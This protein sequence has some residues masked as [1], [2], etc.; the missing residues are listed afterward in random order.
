MRDTLT[1]TRL[2]QK[3]LD[4]GLKQADLAGQVGISASYL[5]LIEH[6][7]RGIS[8]A[9]LTSIA[10]ALA[11]D[12]EHLQEGGGARLVAAL[13]TLGGPE[14]AGDFAA[15]FPD[16]AEFLMRQSDRISALE[17]TVSGLDDRLSHDPVLT[18][19]MHDVL[20]T[21]SA[22]RSTSSILVETP[23]LEADWRARFHANIDA[24]SRRLAET[25]A[26]MVAHFDKIG[27]SD[28]NF[29]TPLEAVY[30][31]FDTHGFFIPALEQDPTDAQVA[32]F[33]A[34]HLADADAGARDL[35]TTALRRYIRVARTMP[36]EPFISTAI[37][38]AHDP[39]ALAKAFDTGLED[40]FL[41]YAHLPMRPDLPEIGF[42]S[43][44][45][46]G[47]LTMRRPAPGF[48]MPRFG[49]ACPLWPLFAAFTQSPR[50]LRKRLVTM[51]GAVYTAY[52]MAGSRAAQEFDAPPI[53]TAAMLL[54]RAPESEDSASNGADFVG[55][56]C[57][58]CTKAQ[59]AA[60][61]EGSIL[62]G[63]NL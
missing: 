17:E 11:I 10:Q 61:R 59:C 56:S 36:A 8:G 24:E 19:K 51:E 37:A 12:P 39:S 27:Q 18:E 28:R 5:N 13:E 50:P 9:L 4:L 55:S 53:L 44:D 25:S 52:A 42:V 58:V 38:Q 20:S 35:V 7:R 33:V 63:A 6:N 40:V 48:A 54:I 2:R 21:V 49:A 57:R 22:I 62:P 1:G 16:W 45:M 60:R 43:C 47:G 14:R 3:R 26:A 34:E 41:R 32:T 46:A 31:F 29:A 30:Q 23:E 15:R